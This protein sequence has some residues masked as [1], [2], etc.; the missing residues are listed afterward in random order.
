MQNSS[1]PRP[2]DF[3]S[4]RDCGPPM[5]PRNE[6]RQR[7]Q[8]IKIV[9]FPGQKRRRIGGGDQETGW[10]SM[11]GD[12]P[13]IPDFVIGAKRP[14]KVEG[15]RSLCSRVQQERLTSA[16]EALLED[17]IRRKAFWA[18]IK[19]GVEAERAGRVHLGI[20]KGRASAIYKE[21]GRSGNA[22]SWFRDQYF[23][24]VASGRIRKGCETRKSTAADAFYSMLAGGA[25]VM[26]DIQ[27]SLVSAGIVRCSEDVKFTLDFL[28][29]ARFEPQQVLQAYFPHISRGISSNFRRCPDPG[30]LS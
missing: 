6:Q 5:F 20:K 4:H 16:A 27:E 18:D 9:G 3:Q 21:L 14:F 11:D 13:V 29:D 28:G 26:R 12:A 8:F 30:Q 10:G 1:K 15:P 23:R 7:K 19:D 2:I 22:L 25:S 17:Y 24:E